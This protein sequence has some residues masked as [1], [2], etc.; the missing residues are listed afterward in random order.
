M[1]IFETKPTEQSNEKAKVALKV[2]EW[3]IEHLTKFIEQAKALLK[4]LE[5]RKAKSID[6]T[7]ALLKSL[8]DRKVELE[9]Q[10]N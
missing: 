5:D 2:Y 8:E 1:S 9:K 3:E 7:K 6:Q 4:S 10:I